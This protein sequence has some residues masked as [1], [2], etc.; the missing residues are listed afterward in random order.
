MCQ[1]FVE[2]SLPRFLHN[3]REK[4]DYGII[5]RD[6]RAK[7]LFRTLPFINKDDLSC[8]SKSRT[9]DDLQ[10]RPIKSKSAKVK[11]QLCRTQWHKLLIY[12]T[13]LVFYG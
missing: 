10:P 3:P 2:S 1:S 8:E 11:V 6:G 4:T 12:E 7:T 5:K 13:N 9:N